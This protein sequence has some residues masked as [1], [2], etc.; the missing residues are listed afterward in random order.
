ML[1]KDIITAFESG[2]FDLD[3]TKSTDKTL[4]RRVCMD[5]RAQHFK[6]PPDNKSRKIYKNPKENF[7]GLE[8][9]EPK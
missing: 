3:A 5:Q 2:D 6:E 4:F 7:P 9:K 1:T 8:Y